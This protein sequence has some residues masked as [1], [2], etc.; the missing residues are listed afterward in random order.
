MPHFTVP[1]ELT[2]GSRIATDL[3]GT[4]MT[5]LLDNWA[6]F[7]TAGVVLGSTGNNQTAM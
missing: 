5:T 6:A 3:K 2:S 7:G 4:E 1:P